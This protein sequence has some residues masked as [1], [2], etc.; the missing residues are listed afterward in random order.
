MNR[1]G[2]P[3]PPALTPAKLAT[4]GVLSVVLVGVLYSQFSSDDSGP[5]VKRRQPRGD[6]SGGTTPNGSDGNQQAQAPS[7]RAKWP[8]IPRDEV[9][10]FNPFAVPET[11]LPKSP[12]AAPDPQA[13]QVAASSQTTSTPGSIQPDPTAQGP[14][15]K[16]DPAASLARAQERKSRKKKM[17]AT[18]RALKTQG[19]GL[20]MT[21]SAGAV[22]RIGDQEVRVGDVINGVLRVVD[23]NS[24]GLVVEE[25]DA[26]EETPAGAP[27]TESLRAL[28]RIG[29]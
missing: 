11:L 21:T 27:T 1:P 6:A 2:T 29:N 26:D 5:I 9:A 16:E 23:I 8:E 3:P 10:A 17:Q 22:A 12:D 28:P 20:I 7:V 19:V 14:S 4:I 15:A 25:V 24:Q 13:L 18:A